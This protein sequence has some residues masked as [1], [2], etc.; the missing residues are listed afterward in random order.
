[1]THVIEKMALTEDKQHLLTASNTDVKLWRTG[2]EDKK[3]KS[4]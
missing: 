1:M 4:R 3:V 2:S